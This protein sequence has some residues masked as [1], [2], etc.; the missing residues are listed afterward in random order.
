MVGDYATSRT[1]LSNPTD[2]LTLIIKIDASR[3]VGILYLKVTINSSWFTASSST[4]KFGGIMKNLFMFALAVLAAFSTQ[5]NAWEIEKWENHPIQ[6]HGSFGQGWI[7]TSDNDWLTLDTER[8]NGDFSFNDFMLNGSIVLNDSLT[9][10]AQIISRDFGDVG[11]NEIDLDWGYFDYN[12]NEKLGFRLGRIKQPN[13]LYGDAWDLDIARTTVFLPPTYST[14]YRDIFV[15]FDGASVYGELDM[16]KFGSLSYTAVYGMK[17]L[18]NDSSLEQVYEAIVGG[19]SNEEAAQ[20]KALYGGRIIW[21]TPLEGLRL[22]FSIIEQ[23]D[24]DTRI[25]VGGGAVISNIDLENLTQWYFSAEYT[26]GDWILSAE[27]RRWDFTFQADLFVP[28][29][30]ASTSSNADYYIQA[31]NQITDKFSAV[32]GWGQA[33]TNYSKRYHGAASSLRSD[34]YISGRY[35]ISDNFLVKADI[36]YIDG[37]YGNYKESNPSRNH[38]LFATKAVFYF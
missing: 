19:F 32:V 30:A 1:L 22:G 25:N 21:D 20:S 34:A 9:L 2:I 31:E 15:S 6:I 13:G 14:E 11:N 3:H 33:T 35:D 7:N 16:G 38:W 8:G 12:V 17:Q 10:G 29:A 26:R 28:A 36:H 5:A 37:T 18:R 4:T 23:K 24:F 27:M